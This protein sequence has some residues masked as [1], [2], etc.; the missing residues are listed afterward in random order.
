[1][2]LNVSLPALIHQPVLRGLAQFDAGELSVSWQGAVAP[3]R[4]LDLRAALK[5]LVRRGGQVAPDFEARTHLEEEA[6]GRFRIEAPLRITTPGKTSDLTAT[7]TLTV[8]NGQN[9]LAL[10]IDSD[11]IVL[12]DVARLASAFLPSEEGTAE[13]KPGTAGTKPGA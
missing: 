3:R 4:R 12:E 1:A 13:R 11:R 10:S 9:S 5:G 8:E 7:G 2:T 6:E